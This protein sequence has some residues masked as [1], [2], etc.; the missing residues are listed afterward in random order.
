ML[1][2][3][4]D[5]SAQI[6]LSEKELSERPDD[7]PHILLTRDQLLIVTKKDQVQHSVMENTVF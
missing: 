6:S 7:S 2:N 1:C 3:L 5:A 4:Q